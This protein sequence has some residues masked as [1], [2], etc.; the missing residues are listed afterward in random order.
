[1]RKERRQV[2]NEGWMQRRRDRE[3]ENQYNTDRK[4]LKTI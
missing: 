2:E 3:R 1:M 4:I